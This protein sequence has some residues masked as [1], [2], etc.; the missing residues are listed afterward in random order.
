M[1]VIVRY[2]K[3]VVY[4]PEGKICLFHFTGDVFIEDNQ[5][6]LESATKLTTASNKV[7][8]ESYLYFEDFR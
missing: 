6:V 4:Q 5:L 1:K 3:K 7:P 2:L 8:G